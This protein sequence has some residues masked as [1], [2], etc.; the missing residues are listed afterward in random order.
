MKVKNTLSQRLENKAIA[1]FAL[2]NSNK[3]NIATLKKCLIVLCTEFVE[4]G[5]WNATLVKTEFLPYIR[6][7]FRDYKH[8]NL[9]LLSNSS[10]AS[11]LNNFKRNL[12]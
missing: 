6:T 7:N 2:F 1:L 3:I 11:L 4:A 8:G 10:E 5:L 12:R 9:S